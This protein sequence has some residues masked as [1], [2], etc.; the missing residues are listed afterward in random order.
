[1]KTGIRRRDSLIQ[2]VTT[3]V[4][5]LVNP[6]RSSQ[7]FDGGCFS[8]SPRHIE[9]QVFSVAVVTGSIGVLSAAHKASRHN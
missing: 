1:M 4:K 9:T 2:C 7:T 5:V 8:S 6:Q 3:R